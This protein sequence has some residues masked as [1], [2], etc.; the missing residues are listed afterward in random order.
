MAKRT[1]YLFPY[2]HLLMGM[3]QRTSDYKKP[4]LNGKLYI[5]VQKLP[6]NPGYMEGR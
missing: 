6:E 3:K 2:E 4:L 5:S 1:T